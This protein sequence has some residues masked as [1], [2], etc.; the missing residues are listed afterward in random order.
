M[1]CKINL[2]AISNSS[3]KATQFQF[4]MNFDSAK[5]DFDS[6]TCLK[7]GVD[8]CQ[9]VGVLPTQ[10]AIGTAVQGPGVVR[11]TITKSGEAVAISQAYLVDNSVLGNPYVLDLIFSLKTNVSANA[12]V[13][14]SLTEML[15]SDATGSKLSATQQPDGL[16]VTEKGGAGPTCGDNSCNGDETCTTCPGDCG[17]C[18]QSGWCKLSG[19]QGQKVN[20][21]VNLAAENSGSAKATQFQFD[22]NFDSAKVKFD[23]TTC[24]KNGVDL[25]N[26]VGVLPTQHAVQTAEQ[27]PGV[28]RLTLTKS[29]AAVAISQAYL[30]GAVV[31]GDAWVLDL[32]FELKTTVSAGVPAAVTLT[33]MLGSE[34]TG[35][36]LSATQQ[37]DGLI[38]TKE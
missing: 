38:V 27:A 10:H 33:Q 11:L 4:D 28:V 29:G 5:V 25:C 2:T 22:M 32:V 12:A 20:C 7:N 19:S 9:L 35:S 31:Q 36:K 30:Q 6:T 26:L 3:P 23:S 21:A 8:L 24:L 1:Q 34:A 17:A 16:I 13:Q 14:V 37:A 15:G 18:P